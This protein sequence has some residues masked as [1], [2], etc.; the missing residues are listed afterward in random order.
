MFSRTATSTWSWPLVM[1]ASVVAVAMVFRSSPVVSQPAVSVTNDQTQAQWVDYWE[2]SLRLAEAD[3]KLAK[4][5][6]ERIKGS[7]SKYDLQRLQ[8]RRDFYRQARSKLGQGID[9]GDVTAGYA[10]LNAKLAELDVQAAEEV[11]QTYPGEIWDVQ[12][13]R[14][15]AHAEVCRLQADLARDPARS[16]ALIDHL[17]GET[18]RMA[19]EILQLQQRVSHLEEVV[20]R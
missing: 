17:H 20:L 2:A 11:R 12:Y 19:A 13:E 3:L 5:S 1:A 4:L 15:L 8:L 14:A 18:H 6:N 10:E 16:A 7:V 9:F